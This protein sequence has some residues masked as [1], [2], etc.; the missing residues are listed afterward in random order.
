MIYT[1]KGH[2]GKLLSL[3]QPQVMGIINATPDSFYTKGTNSKL[4]EMVDL[5][6]KMIEDGATILDI[7]G[8]STRPGS[9]PVSEQEELDRVLPALEAIRKSFPSIFISIDTYRSKIAEESILRGADIINDISAGDLDEAMI[10]TIAKYGATY[11][12]MHMKGTPQNMQENPKYEDIL[13]EIMFYFIHKINVLRQHKIHD[14]ILDVGFGFGK[15]VEDN[16]KIL[17]HL[18]GF[19]S[20]EYPLLA[21]ISRK[22]MFQKLLDI[23]PEQALNATTVGH[24]LALQQGAHIL[25]VHDVKEAKEAI[26]ILNFLQNI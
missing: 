25:R 1:I 20:F 16:F 17:K 21:G 14:I 2:S 23:T 10:S 5:A 19:Q 15:T 8:M 7:G 13:N 6:G 26:K 12:I 11:L 4:S 24:V 18:S 3:E 9:T 22:S